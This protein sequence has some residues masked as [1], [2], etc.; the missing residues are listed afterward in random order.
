MKLKGKDYW[1][2]A[3]RKYARIYFCGDT[4]RKVRFALVRTLKAWEFFA[5]VKFNYIKIIEIWVKN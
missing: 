2:T 3:S 5:A 4:V 1:A